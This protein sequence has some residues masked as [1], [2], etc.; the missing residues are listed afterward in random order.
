MNNEGSWED[1]L[2]S[3]NAI[4]ISS[5]RKKAR[6]LVNTAKGRNMYLGRNK[7][8][9]VSANYIF[10]GYYNSVI[11][12]VHSLALLHGFKVLNHLCLGHFLREVIKDEQLYRLFDD[13]RYKRNSLV[14]YG[15]AME[16]LVAKEA[17]EKCKRLIAQLLA[18][19]EK[20]D[21]TS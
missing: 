1:C 3:S 21:K 14:Y 20:K 18:L 6:S 4:A 7:M 12:L 15:T 16:F 2:E 17:I 11:E 8:D 13:C 10:E 9:E 5:N 19:Y